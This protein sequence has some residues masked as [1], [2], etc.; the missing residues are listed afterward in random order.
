MK[1]RTVRKSLSKLEESA[2]QIFFLK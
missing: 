2:L 1:T